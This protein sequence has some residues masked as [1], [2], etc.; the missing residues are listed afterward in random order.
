M[1]GNIDD[2]T[3]IDSNRVKSSGVWTTR[4]RD[5][6]FARHLEKYSKRDK[7]MVENIDDS[8]RI[9]SN[10]RI[11]ASFWGQHSKTS[12]TS[13]SKMTCTLSLKSST[14]STSKLTGSG[15]IQQRR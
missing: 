10:R 13:A 14:A 15:K 7:G 12:I 8:T 2:S 1:V 5:C 4:L 11:N 3:R 9:D 6:R